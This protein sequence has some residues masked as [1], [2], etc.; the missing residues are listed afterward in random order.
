VPLRQNKLV[1]SM[2]DLKVKAPFLLEWQRIGDDDGKL[3]AMR[4]AR[5]GGST[6]HHI[7]RNLSELSGHRYE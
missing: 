1:G 4:G 6:N 5:Q 7:G 3:A 2:N